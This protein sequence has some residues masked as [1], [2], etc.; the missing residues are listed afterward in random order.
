MQSATSAS[1]DEAAAAVGPPPA[2]QASQISESA[3]LMHV[4]AWAVFSTGLLICTGRVVIPLPPDRIPLPHRREVPSQEQNGTILEAHDLG[5][6]LCLWGRCWCQHLLMLC[7]AIHAGRQRL[8]TAWGWQ[9]AG[10][11]KRSS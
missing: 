11:C 5:S 9:A 6:D 3:A 4:H 1:S 8:G 7:G 10:L 2:A